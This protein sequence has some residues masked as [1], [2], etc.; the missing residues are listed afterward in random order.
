MTFAF[1]PRRRIA[2][3]TAELTTLSASTP[4]RRENLPQPRCGFGGDLEDGVADAEPAAGREVLLAEVEVDVELIAR[5]RPVGVL[6]AVGEQG[7]RAG[8]HDR[9]LRLR[10]CR[11]S[12]ALVG[13]VVA[14]QPEVAG[15]AFRTRAARAPRSP[16]GGPAARA[17]PRPRGAVPTGRGPPRVHL[18]SDRAR[19][20]NDR[21]SLGRLP[22][23]A[24]PGRRRLDA[25]RHARCERSRPGMRRR[26]RS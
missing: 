19:R 24:R 5:P 6:G 4:K 25:L 2:R 10:V 15:R 12:A 21:P 16:G 14:D 9:D 3:P 18:G 20:D 1:R 26:S 23:K 22:T 8:V 13:P 17:D 7:R 11:A